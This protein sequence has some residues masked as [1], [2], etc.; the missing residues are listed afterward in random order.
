MTKVR[1][2][3]VVPFVS[4]ASYNPAAV[5]AK[6]DIRKNP[7]QLIPW[8][9]RS[10]ARPAARI[11]FIV[12]CLSAFECTL[13]FAAKARA[14][15]SRKPKSIAA[16]ID[17]PRDDTELR[18]AAAP[19]VID[20]FDVVLTL[21]P[22]GRLEVQENIE[23]TFN[24][25]RHGIVRK[26]PRIRP[27][28]SGEFAYQRI[29]VA[30]SH[31]KPW[32]KRVDESASYVSIRVGSPD[33]LLRGRQTFKI[34]YQVDEAALGS[35]VSKQ[36]QWFVTG[37]QWNAPIRSARVRFE[38]PAPPGSET[39]LPA[40]RFQAFAGKHG[41]ELPIL[42]NRASKP[43][44]FEATHNEILWPGD[45]LTI[46]ASFPAALIISPK[47]WQ[48]FPLRVWGWV[49]GTWAAALVMLLLQSVF[50]FAAMRNATKMLHASETLPP[51]VTP[52][53]L[54]VLREGKL[55]NKALQAGATYLLNRG[56]L[57]KDGER[58][59][60]GQ[61]GTGLPSADDWLRR[62][63]IGRRVGDVPLD[64]RPLRRLV[65]KRLVELCAIDHEG[66]ARAVTSN[67]IGWLLSL[68][69]ASAWVV[70]DIH[71][72]SFLEFLVL[73]VLTR[74]QIARRMPSLLWIP[75]LLLLAFVRV[76]THPSLPDWDMGLLAAMAGPA[77]AFCLVWL[78]G[79]PIMRIARIRPLVGWLSPLGW[80]MLA[81][82]RGLVMEPADALHAYRVALG[83]TKQ[84]PARASQTSHAAEDNTWWWQ[85]LNERSSLTG[86]SPLYTFGFFSSLFGADEGP[87]QDPVHDDSSNH[88]HSW[89]HSDSSSYSDSST[90]YS[91][92]SSYGDSSSWSSSDS[93]SDSSG[94]GSDW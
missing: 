80:Q 89:S 47:L 58:F 45:G 54:S 42:S 20:L 28:A 71:L 15:R 41:E 18:L 5:A 78:A 17:L 14:T 79:Y 91:D 77:L 22:Q 9:A 12:A 25:A 53:E 23:V 66:P 52:L 33:A 49:L 24:E 38:L 93:S 55:T 56:F 74:R 68:G 21:S 4:G 36:L 19:Y 92:S 62:H 87:Y 94:G 65:Y 70:A 8:S 75:G 1:R 39:T 59:K 34:R 16:Q 40:S 3:K 44:S 43:N 83:H 11:A 61:E 31:G 30:N 57:V 85:G 73:M 76:Q 13:A 67:R 60:R 86:H 84:P 63:L 50:K 51:D 7:G 46:T 35:G 90:S 32:Q 82:Y 27:T 72:S 88:R 64:A 69:G 37:S 6:K 2:L 48:R 29:A 10:W 81:R 26:L